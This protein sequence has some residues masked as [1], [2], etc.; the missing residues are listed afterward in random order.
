[1]NR[2]GFLNLLAKATAVGIALP[3]LEQLDYLSRMPHSVYIADRWRIV[4]DTLTVAADG[5]EQFRIGDLITA[6]F[7]V[8]KGTT[9]KMT[10]RIKQISASRITHVDYAVVTAQPKERPKPWPIAFWRGKDMQRATGNSP[11]GWK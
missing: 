10:S 1:M 4:E 5:M 2:R 7:P 6:S 8:K 11:S 3:T 9:Y